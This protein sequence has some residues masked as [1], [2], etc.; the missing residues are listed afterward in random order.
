M[1]SSNITFY[2][3]RLITSYESISNAL[4]ILTLW[5]SLIMV[6]A[7]QTRIKSSLNSP[8]SFIFFL[9]CLNLVLVLAFY[10]TRVVWFYFFF[11]VSLVPT[12]LL[13]LGWGYQPERLQASI[14]IIL[15]TVTA[16]LPLLLTILWYTATRNVSRML[17]IASFR[18]M[19]VVSWGANIFLFLILLAFLV[20]LPIFSVHLWLPKAHV[21]APVAGSI[22]L[23]AILLK[24]GGYGIIRI[25]QYFSPQTSFSSSFII[26]LALWGGL[27]TRIMC[28]RQIDF[29]ALIAYS[30]V[31]HIS[32]MLAGVLRN[33]RWGWN[34]AMILIVSH[35]FCSSALFALANYTYEKSHSRRLLLAKGM[36]CLV[37]RLSLWWFIFSVINM[38]GPP[39]I[40]LLGEIIIFPSLIFNS[41]FLVLP[42]AM[43]RFFSAL[44][45]MYLYTCTQH[46]AAPK[47]EKPFGRMRS[48]PLILL[49]LHW[50]PANFLILKR[51]LILLIS[52]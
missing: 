46:G 24:L 27:L 31:G 30:S 48:Q 10:I 21:E 16:S 4:I 5:I 33:T 32:L 8:D 47:Y 17:L 49:V 51:E 20:K 28:F 44:Y 40:N 18:D 38:A 22:V 1:F 41:L 19:S 11:E 2:T 7:S 52:Y 42:L 6:L 37:P 50:L 23:A 29:K 26:R 25:Y 45:R 39:R 43:I 34:G 13:I 9:I 35:G 15:Y 3:N 12:L 36:L 14:Y